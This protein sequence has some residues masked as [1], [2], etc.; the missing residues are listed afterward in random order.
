MCGIVGA[1]A[2]RNVVGILLE[3]LQRL[4]YRGYDSAGLTVL[5]AE[6]DLKRYRAVGKVQALKETCRAESP[7]G[8]IGIAHTRWATHGKPTQTNAHPHVSSDTV[9]LVHNGIIENHEAL[10]QE[11]TA[12]GYRFESETDTEVMAHLIH[13]LVAGCGDFRQGVTEALTRLE[14]AYAIAVQHRDFPDR[15]IGAR[16]GSPLVVGLGIGENFIASDPQALRPVT[17]RFIYL[18]EG[19]LVELTQSEVSIFG[20]REG[21]VAS[22]AVTL[23]SRVDAADKGT[24]RHFMLKEKY[25]QPN[26]IRNTLQGR[27]GKNSILS[28]AFG[29]EAGLLFEQTQ[30]VQIVACGTS[31][32]SALVAK[33]W[34][35]ALTGLICQV[36]I[37][38][39]WRY[40][41]VA[42][43][44]NTLFLTISQSGETADTLAA[45]RQSKSL[46]YLGSLCICNV[47]NS[48]LVRES[49]LCL[50]TEAGT[51][52]GVAST[53]AFT[54]QLADLL[55]FAMALGKYHDLTP[56]IESELV[57]ALHDLPTRLEETLEVDQQVKAWAEQFIAKDHALFLGRGLHYPIA[58][59]GALKLKEISYIHA[60][61]YPAGELKHGPLALV[62][63]QM[64][65]VCVAPTDE[66]LEKV[67]S[68]LQEV[69]AR[70]GS[71]YVFTD[72]QAD[73]SDLSETQVIILPTVHPMLAPIA[74]VLPLQLLSCHV[75][76]LR[77]TDVDQ[78]RN[79]AKS[80]TVE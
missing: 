79:L 29:V 56:E 21:S 14:G 73:F 4:E 9:S 24:F 55:M 3:G 15:L 80:V 68:N 17:D 75:A 25:E 13:H 23:D 69:A 74:F 18:E 16:Q 41:T 32:Y 47:P 67:K 66:L 2:E 27:I 63:E 48:S 12:Q 44:P 34:V 64:P 70:G 7:K 40:R 51:E 59:E 35:E 71:L 58:M 26:A 72:H 49:D 39:E 6:Q 38:S 28:Q 50:M 45:L 10:R 31:Y 1:A 53:K 33:Y 77:G 11:L 30:A 22:R 5:N 52:I 65:V 46:G 76:V 43:A 8:S 61:G 42:V 60:E 54:T 78:P 20:G 19:E 36:E 37:A 57:Q 62:D